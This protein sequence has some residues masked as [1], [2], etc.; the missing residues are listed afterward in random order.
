MSSQVVIQYLTRFAIVLALSIIAVWLVSELG[1]LLQNDTARAPMDVELVIPEGTAASVAAGNEGPSIPDEMTFVQGDVLVVVN[2]DT[3]PHSLGPLYVPP[4]TSASMHLDDADNFALNCS[5]N[6]TRYF[7]LNV[8]PP[9]TLRTRLTG[10]A[11][12]APPTAAML[13]VYSL[14][15]FPL[16]PLGSAAAAN[17]TS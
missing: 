2:H 7:G 16:K 13:F 12:A 15:V 4:Q 8:K 5:F 3:E 11:F 10:I 6:S 17:K 1:V 9:T 14:I